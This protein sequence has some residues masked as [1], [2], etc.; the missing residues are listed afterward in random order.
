MDFPP[1]M[2]RDAVD[3]IDKML[4]LDINKRLGCG[5]SDSDNDFNAIKNH[6]FFKDINFDTLKD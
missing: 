5:P 2:P 1:D 6:P 3:L 4:N